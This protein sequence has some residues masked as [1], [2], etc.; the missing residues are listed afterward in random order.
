MD[1]FAPWPQIK[2]EVALQDL[3][4]ISSG[5]ALL[6]WCNSSFLLRTH[7]TCVY[8]CC[9]ACLIRS[10]VIM[11]IVSM[12]LYSS[13]LFG[14]MLRPMNIRTRINN[15]HNEKYKVKVH[16]VCSHPC[17]SHFLELWVRLAETH[18]GFQP[19]WKLPLV[20]WL[21]TNEGMVAWGS[22]WK[23]QQT[24]RSSFGRMVEFWFGVVQR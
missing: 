5:V 24:R 15:L 2:E 10:S 11:L 19:T 14:W 1:M 3:R 23:N 6:I 9:L 22:R 20:D 7:H 8:S 16:L 17:S 13:L 12:P 21:M 18:V 4:I